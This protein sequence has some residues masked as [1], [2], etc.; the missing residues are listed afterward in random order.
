MDKTITVKLLNPKTAIFYLSF[1][2]QFAD[3]SASLPVWGQILVLGIIVNFMFSIT[4]AACVL[5]SEKMK[6]GL[7]ASHRANR[8]A[9]R[10][11][12]GILVAL[13]INLAMSR[14]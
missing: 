10:I 5:L 13:G 7:V 12:G 1:L 3:A 2:P 9:Q 6:R 8:L 11:G 4:D 14:Q